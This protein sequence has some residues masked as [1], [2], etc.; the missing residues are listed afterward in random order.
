MENGAADALSRDNCHS[1]FLQV[2]QDR[3]QPATNP[4]A[5]LQALVLQQPDWEHSELNRLASHYCIKGLTNSTHKVY[6]S[7]QRRFGAFCRIANVVSVP[8]A[9]STLCRFVSHL[10]ADNALGSVLHRV[11]LFPQVWGNDS[12]E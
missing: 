5:I 7:A 8:V 2:P 3:H 4:P 6:G 10:A 9:E 11:F 1:F 12:T